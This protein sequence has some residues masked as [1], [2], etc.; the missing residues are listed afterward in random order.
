[1]SSPS[2]RSIMRTFCFRAVAWPFGKSAARRS[3]RHFAE[4]HARL[5]SSVERPGRAGEG[6]RHL[7]PPSFRRLLRDRLRELFSAWR[8]WEFPDRDVTNCFS[9]ERC[10]ART[11]PF[12]SASWDSIPPMRA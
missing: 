9:M 4:L 12:C 7:G 6:M 11:A 3:M 1:M 10:E 5:P 8:D 2:S